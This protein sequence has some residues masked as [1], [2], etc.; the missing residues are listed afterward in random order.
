MSDVIEIKAIPD[1]KY[2]GKY[3]VSKCGRAF[4]EVALTPNDKGYLRLTISVYGKR[5]EEY[6]HRLVAKT[7]LGKDLKGMQVDHNDKNK[8]NNK[9]SNLE[10]VSM[11][12]NLKRKYSGYDKA[13]I[14]LPGDPF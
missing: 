7:F 14:S 2:D 12:E 9:I 8:S 6:I 10:V 11:D 13:Q 1:K 3:F 5:V 4:R